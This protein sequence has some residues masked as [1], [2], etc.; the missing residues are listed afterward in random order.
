MIA[1]R[2][3]MLVFETDMYDQML[4]W[5]AIEAEQL[6]SPTL[7]VSLGKAAAD[8]LFGRPPLDDRIEFPLP[9]L[10]LLNL[11]L[12]ERMVSRSCTGCASGRI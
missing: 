7:T 8:C 12:L 2:P 10:M 5:R 3:T 1:D 11:K 6:P 9:V 4:T